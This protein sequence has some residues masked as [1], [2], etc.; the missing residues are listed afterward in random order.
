M[1]IAKCM[2]V[3]KEL[4]TTEQLITHGAWDSVETGGKPCQD[5]LASGEIAF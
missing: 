1:G 5:E 3:C 4:N 2:G